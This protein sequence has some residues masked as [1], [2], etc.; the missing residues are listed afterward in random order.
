MHNPIVARPQAPPNYRCLV[1]S[2]LG[3]QLAPIGSPENQT[4]TDATQVF[5]TV[6]QPACSVFG[7]IPVRSSDI[8]T[9][10]EIPDQVYRALREW[11]LV[12][13]DLTEA[14]PNVMYEL[15]LRHVTGLCTIAIAEYKRLPFDV[16]HIRTEQFVRSEA[17]LLAGRELLIGAI[18]AVLT[19]GCDELTVGRIFRRDPAT[20]AGRAAPTMREIDLLGESPQGGG[21]P[22][23][24]PSTDEPEPPGLLDIL[25]ES[26]DALPRIVDTIGGVGEVV[27]DLGNLAAEGSRD[28][29]ALQERGIDSARERLIVVARIAAGFEKP[30]A[31]L[32]SL[33]ASYEHDLFQVDRANTFL[34]DRFDASA[35]EAAPA[36]EYLQA[37]VNMGETSKESFQSSEELAH[38]MENL[39]RGARVLRGP[40]A[41]V[42]LTLRR[43]IELNAPIA[44]WA[45]RARAVLDRLPP[46]V[47]TT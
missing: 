41:R 23:T 5:G 30:A 9:P 26:E 22:L 38:N 16:G 40:S 4:Y 29:E 37:L 39:G 42:A 33:V 28:I 19:T 10:G 46:T 36:A 43:F 27:N 15:A 12:I 20:E 25:A 8:R 13:A 17:G 31:H 47:P 14:N 7:I 24:E 32:E 11:E 21:A 3:S 2:P 34:L 1:I 45:E 18:Q 35:E 44:R 6:I